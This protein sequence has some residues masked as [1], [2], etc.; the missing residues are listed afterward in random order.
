[1]KGLVRAAYPRASASVPRQAKH[2]HP[3][4]IAGGTWEAFERVMQRAGY[5][6]GGLPK[7][8]AARAIAQHM[9]PSRNTSPSFCALRDAL[10]EMGGG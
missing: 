6:G 10:R 2:R 8:D 1:M 9:D 3:D 5:F 7:I 4:R